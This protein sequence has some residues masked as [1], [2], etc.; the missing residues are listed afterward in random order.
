MHR[1]LPWICV[2]ALAGCGDNDSAPAG[3]GQGF[4]GPEGAAG[5]GDASGTGDGD[6][7]VAAQSDTTPLC[8][9]APY[10]GELSGRIDRDTVL[11]RQESPYDLQGRLTISEGATL[12]VEPGVT[13]RFGA[14]GVIHVGDDAGALVARGTQAKPILFTSALAAPAP[15]DWQGIAFLAG[16]Q[17]DVSQLEHVI[18]EYAGDPAI[19]VGATDVTIERTTIRHCGGAALHLEAGGEPARLTELTFE[20]NGAPSLSV[21]PARW[22]Q[23][24][25][26]HRFG[27]GDCIKVRGGAIEADV[28][29]PAATVPYCVAADVT[30]AGGDA[31]SLTLQAGVRAEFAAGV[32][33]RA[34]VLVLDGTQEQPVTLTAWSPHPQAGAWGGLHLTSSAEPSRLTHAYVE[35]AGS[36]GAALRI[37]GQRPALSDVTIRYSSD[38]GVHFA[39]AAAGASSF[40]SVVFDGIAE[41][42]VRIGA[43]R[44]GDLKT[45]QADGPSDAVEVT[46]GRIVQD[47]TWPEL[48]VSWRLLG[49]LSVANEARWTVPAGA[50]IEA[51]TVASIVIGEVDGDPGVLFARGDADRPIQIAPILGGLGWGGLRFAS[52]SA[53][54]ALEHVRIDDARGDACVII[55]RG[56]PVIRNT[57]VSGC[58]GGGIVARGPEAGFSAFEANRFI[59]PAG[60]TLTIDAAR[61]GDIQGEH[62]ISGDAAFILVTGDAI[63]ADTTWK[64]LGVPW[65][66]ASQSVLEV[67]GVGAGAALTIEAGVTVRF[68]AGAG[69]Y[70]GRP[71]TGAGDLVLLGTPE[72]PVR[73]TPAT[74][75]PT[76]GVWRGIALDA[77]AHRD[78]SRLEH[79]VVEFAGQGIDVAGV[80]HANLVLKDTDVQVRSAQVRGS[81]G[82]GIE[83]TGGAPTLTDITYE[84]NQ[85]GDWVRW[86]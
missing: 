37:E 10:E 3:F 4:G 70:V 51:A 20:D 23:V 14:G 62:E 19:A 79:F 80:R 45:F 9:G 11:I 15:G 47:S 36:Q 35:Y 86:D 83:I 40:E 53:A 12:C 33:L 1:A 8:V 56:R 73:F 48:G 7:G 25:G 32:V 60:P 44:V 75:D 34:G 42:S 29:V 71:E 85:M 5:A 18:V 68:D 2:L 38:L 77:G 58:A 76:G 41:A 72:A 82:F 30:V 28:T 84:A 26:G 6:A 16:N 64:E 57:T 49:K 13:V 52:T 55:D 59:D 27:A 31:P 22:G 67:A 43:G 24:G 81:T 46:S 39:D 74:D 61:S 65:V 17:G 69:L 63:A 50:V 54:S 21:D 78:I 66:I